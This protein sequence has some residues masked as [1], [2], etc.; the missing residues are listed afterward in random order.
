MRADVADRECA[1]VRGH[2][3]PGPPDTHETT[4]IV[5][6]K[7]TLGAGRTEFKA[8]H[9]RFSRKETF[10]VDGPAVSRPNG[11]TDSSVFRA[12][13]I[14]P[15]TCGDIEQHQFSRIRGECGDVTAVGRPAQAEHAL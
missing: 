14:G 10:N 12:K 15:L 11:I 5:S 8:V 1:S 7:K 2:A 6:G 13:P 4:Q 9:R 3:R